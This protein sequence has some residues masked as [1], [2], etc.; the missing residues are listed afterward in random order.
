MI[1][2]DSAAITAPGMSVMRPTTFNNANGIIVTM[3]PKGK[4]E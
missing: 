3:L 2:A 1:L 4:T